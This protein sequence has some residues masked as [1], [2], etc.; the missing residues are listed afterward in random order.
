MPR[1]QARSHDGKSRHPTSGRYFSSLL[2]KLIAATALI[3]DLTVMTRNVADFENTGARVLNP[4]NGQGQVE[5]SG[6]EH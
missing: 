2:D 1:K 5:E 3:H 6:R 4:F